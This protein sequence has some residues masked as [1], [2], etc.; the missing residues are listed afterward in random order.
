MIFPHALNETMAG[1]RP[2]DRDKVEFCDIPKN[3]K[4]FPH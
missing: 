1:D 2:A 3:G 4:R